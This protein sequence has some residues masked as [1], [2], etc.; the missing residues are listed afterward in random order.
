MYSTTFNILH[1][2]SQLLTLSQYK[3]GKIHTQN[4]ET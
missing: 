3:K 4:L 2:S 1:F